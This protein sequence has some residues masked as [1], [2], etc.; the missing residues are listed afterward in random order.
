MAPSVGPDG[1]HQLLDMEPCNFS[2]S[3]ID[4]RLV[5]LVNHLSRA[6]ELTRVPSR[7]HPDRPLEIDLAIVGLGTL[8]Q[9][10]E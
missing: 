5:S 7:V 4:A 6:L 3:A 10:P 2:N 1:G 8:R 9:A